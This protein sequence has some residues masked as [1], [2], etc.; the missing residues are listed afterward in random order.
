MS[1]ILGRGMS[2]GCWRGCDG[3]V[4]MEWGRQCEGG[5]GGIFLIS[6]RCRETDKDESDLITPTENR[7]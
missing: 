5:V 2:F 7:L 1:M 3:C 4:E 6:E